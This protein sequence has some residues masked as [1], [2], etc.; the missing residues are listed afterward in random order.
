[1]LFVFRKDYLA[2]FDRLFY[3]CPEL[4]GQSLRLTPPTAGSLHRVIRG[5]FE[6]E[7]ASGRCDKEIT[8]TVASALERELKPREEDMPLNLSEVQ[9]AA[10]QLWRSANPAAI[11]VSRGKEGLIR[12]YLDGRISEFGR[13]RKIAEA[14]LSMMI[15]EEGTRKVVVES[16][17]VSQLPKKARA[18]KATVRG[19][20]DGLVSRTLARRDYNCGATTYEIVSEFLVPWIRELK[21]QRGADEYKNRVRTRAFAVLTAVAIV[22][23]PYFVF[24]R[25]KNKELYRSNAQLVEKNGELAETKRQADMLARAAQERFIQAQKA[26]NCAQSG[27]SRHE[28]LAISEE[29]GFS[30][31]P[32]RPPNINP[33]SSANDRYQSVLSGVNTV[34]A[35]IAPGPIALGLADWNVLVSGTEPSSAFVA[36]RQ[37]REGRVAAV[38]HEWLLVYA[39]IPDNGT[40]VKNLVAWLEQGQGARIIYT[41]GHREWLNQ[42]NAE[43]LSNELGRGGFDLQPLP[44]NITEAALTSVAVLIIGNAWGHFEAEEIAAVE[45]YV[46]RG[47]GLILAGLGWSWQGPMT[48][49]PMTRVAEPYRVGWLKSVITDPDAHYS[50]NDLPQYLK[51]QFEGAPKFHTFYPNAKR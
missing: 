25:T 40:L 33:S 41:T 20:L 14:L 15:T 27:C 38:G 1:M 46:A 16:E 13:D 37:Y 45:S 7:Q 30:S 49:Y 8:E 9:I 10:L 23:V 50:F 34:V 6:S 5:P 19:V 44:G 31:P 4:L 2:K 39:Q 35:G 24:L 11:L 28:I 17:V 12:D 22:G 26:I 29:I 51:A 18:A 48:D 32:S 3:S 36:V 43:Q 42:Q 47:G 21:R